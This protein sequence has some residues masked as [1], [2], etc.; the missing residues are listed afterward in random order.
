MDPARDRAALM[1]DYLAAFDPTFIGATGDRSAL[2]SVMQKYGV[3]AAKQGTGLDYAMSHT[4]S[5]FLIDPG[6]KLRG[7]MPFGHDAADL[8]TKSAIC[9]RIA[10]IA[11]DSRTFRCPHPVRSCCR[12]LLAGPAGSAGADHGA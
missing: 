10:Y 12:S 9:Q 3:T 8:S 1:K 7:L 4:S 11:L 6:G 5:I 2:A